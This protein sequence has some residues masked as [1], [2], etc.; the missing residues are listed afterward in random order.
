MISGGVSII[1]LLS[2]I[3]VSPS[4]TFTL[5]LILSANFW[6]FGNWS[7]ANAFVG[8]TKIAKI[9]PWLDSFFIL[10][11]TGIKNASVFP[12]AVGASITTFSPKTISCIA[13]SWN[14]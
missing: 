2:S 10:W 6:I 9:L 11:I 1:S 3:F 5:I 13:S 12:D 8:Y 4:N 14:L 7:L